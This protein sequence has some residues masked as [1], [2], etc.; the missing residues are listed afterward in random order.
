MMPT[1]FKPPTRHGHTVI[2][3]RST[4]R[5]LRKLVTSLA[6]P[7]TI[8]RVTPHGLSLGKK[9][10]SLRQPAGGGGG[11]GGGGG[12]ARPPPPAPPRPPKVGPDDEGTRV[13]ALD[14]ANRE[15]R[16]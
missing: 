16:I 4:S 6:P 13:L 8:K 14:L 7:S 11:G 3:T 12:L 9:K 1:A 10:G 15:L 2:T 5:A